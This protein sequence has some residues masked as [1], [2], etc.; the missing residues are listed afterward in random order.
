MKLTIERLTAL[1]QQDVIDLEKI[2]PQQAFAPGPLAGSGLLFAARFNARLLAA[3]NVEVT[4][5][6][7]VMTGFTVR[8]VTR[9]RGVGRYLLEETMRQV[10]GMRRWR[11]E[12]DADDAALQAFMLACGFRAVAGYWELAG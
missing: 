12:G 3:V 9:R 10:P 4:G 8:E 5:A 7:A 11:L 6:T 2:W 1:N